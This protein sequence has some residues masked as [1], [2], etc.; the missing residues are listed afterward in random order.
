[1]TKEIIFIENNK[2]C[3]SIYYRCNNKEES[4]T[5]IHFFEKICRV[6]SHIGYD[7]KIQIEDAM[8]DE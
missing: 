5:I 3:C 8:N 6:V 1:M 4:E 7:L 2:I